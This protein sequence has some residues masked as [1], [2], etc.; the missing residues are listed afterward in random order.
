MKEYADAAKFRGQNG[1]TKEGWKSMATR[2]NNQ[3]PIAN[4]VVD[5]LKFREQ[6]LK[7]EYFIVKSTVEKSGF[8]FDPI[9]KML[10]TIP[11]KWDELSKEQQKWRYKAFPYYDDLHAIYDGTLVSHV[12]NLAYFLL[13]CS[14]QSIPLYPCKLAEGKGCK[15]TIDQVEERFSSAT[16]MPQG[17]TFTQ[18]VLN[19][20]LNS[21]SPTL[22]APDFEDQHYEWS[23][24]I[25]GDDVEVFPVENTECLENNSN[26][27][28]T[29]DVNTLPDPPPMKKARASK[30]ND[31]G[32]AKR[33]KD[34]TIEDLVAVRKEELKTYVDVKT[35]QIESYRDVKMALME[36]KNPD[37][38]P[39]CIA[40]CIVKLK[41]MPDLSASEHLKT[42]EYLK[43]QRADREIFMTVEHDVV[44]EILKKVLGRQI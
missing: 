34:T 25:Y 16:D 43:G 17:E 29:E 30:G 38:G 5:Q 12:I 9:N 21:P 6:R 33:G 28:P 31:E 37:K 27:F 14:L 7:K 1:W 8:G 10:T 4:F 19:A 24:G 23:K 40:N 13:A 36:K 44:L 42:I 39:Y 41:T 35:K 20:A 32:K 26:Q 22:P 11:E 15:R 2:L 18:Q 3:F